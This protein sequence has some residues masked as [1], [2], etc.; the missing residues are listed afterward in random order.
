MKKNYDITKIGSFVNT[1]VDRR[2]KSVSRTV[3][4]TVGRESFQ[5]TGRSSPRK[6][7]KIAYTANP[8][9]RVEHKEDYLTIQYG[10]NEKGTKASFVANQTG[11]LGG[12]ALSHRDSLKYKDELRLAT[13]SKFLEEVANFNANV[14][15]VML[16]RKQLLETADALTR[17]AYKYSSNVLKRHKRIMSIKNDAR[18]AEAIKK[19]VSGASVPGLSKS[20]DTIADLWLFSIYGVMPIVMDLETAVKHK[21]LSD[22]GVI[23]ARTKRVYNTFSETLPHDYCTVSYWVDGMVRGH[24]CAYVTITDPWIKMAAEYGFTNPFILAWERIP[25]SFVID[26]FCNIGDWLQGFSA[27]HGVEIKDYSFTLTEKVSITQGPV[28]FKKSAL[29][30]SD[31]SG[32]ILQPVNRVVERKDRSIEPPAVSLSFTPSMNWRRALTSLALTNQQFKKLK[33]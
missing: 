3:T 20:K 22:T 16:E 31:I 21:A 30:W 26:W 33:I 24:S 15:L 1:E 25:Y 6:N 2:G 28:I 5:H 17:K 7:G 13:A 27:L 10:G 18:R 29:G 11:L 23:H 32:T 14:A 12:I 9:A 19:T 4:G 8:Y